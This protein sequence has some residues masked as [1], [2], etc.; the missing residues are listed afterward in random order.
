MINA[1]GGFEEGYTYDAYG[2]VTIYSYAVGD[3]DLDRD[4]DG[5]DNTVFSSCYNKSGNPPRANG[6]DLF[7]MD[8]DFDGDVGGIDFTAFAT[9][10]GGGGVP[11]ADITASSVGNPYFFTGRPMH[12][13]NDGDL[14]V[15]DNRNRTYLPDEGRWLQ[16][17]PIGITDGNSR[18]EYVGNLEP[19]L[20]GQMLAIEQYT[21]GM[22]LYAYA[23]SNPLVYFD[24][25]GL[26]SQQ[27]CA[28]PWSSASGVFFQIRNL[29]D[30]FKNWANYDRK[31]G[32]NLLKRFQSGAISR[33]DYEKR[34]NELLDRFA[35]NTQMANK[36]NS[37]AKAAFE[38]AQIGRWMAQEGCGCKDIQMASV[39]VNNGSNMA[40]AMKTFNKIPSGKGVHDIAIWIVNNLPSSPNTGIWANLNSV[41]K[42]NLMRQT[43]HCCT[44]KFH[45]F[46]VNPPTK[47]SDLYEGTPNLDT[48]SNSTPKNK[49]L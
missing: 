12:P 44:G 17:D 40:K 1:G 25:W 20:L 5:I 47:G 10:Y 31:Q 16:R 37:R 14:Q 38:T 48:F 34:Y 9:N 30:T 35:W 32:Q 18:I 24:P 41:A 28:G 22:N 29:R 23:K 27:G 2:K 33:A 8:Y 11:P 26:I 3:T 7:Y 45:D 46:L 36:L 13:V 43:I 21:D 39:A 4:V 19:F 6:C 15:Q 42:K 49:E